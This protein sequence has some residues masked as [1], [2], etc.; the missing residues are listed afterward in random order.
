M[1]PDVPHA[2]TVMEPLAG[3]ICGGRQIRR[4]RLTPERR[5]ED[6]DIAGYPDP[7]R[8]LTGRRQRVGYEE[9]MA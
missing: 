2:W 9:P 4:L 8:F 5:S 7:C 1:A 3:G 6:P